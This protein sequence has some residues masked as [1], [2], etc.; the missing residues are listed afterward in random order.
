MCIDK[1]IQE[2]VLCGRESDS[3]LFNPSAIC[4]RVDPFANALHVYV[5]L[6]MSVHPQIRLAVGPKVQQGG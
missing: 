5:F 3:R 4:V 1:P 2:V 6:V